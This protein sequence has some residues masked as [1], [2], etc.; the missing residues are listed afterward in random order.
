MLIG[1]AMVLGGVVRATGAAVP[2]L[3]VLFLAL[4]VVRIPF[5]YLMSERWQAEAVWWS[6]PLGSIAAALF[7]WLYYRRGSWKR[8]HMLEPRPAVASAD[9]LLD[10]LE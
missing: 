5:A 10:I 3:V 1:I 9:L 6:F 8:A 7:M 2:P 4:F